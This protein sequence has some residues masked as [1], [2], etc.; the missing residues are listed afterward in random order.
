MLLPAGVAAQEGQIPPMVT[1]RPAPELSGMDAVERLIGN[2]LVVTMTFE[3]DKP[4]Y[5]VFMHLKEDRSA[6][7]TTDLN[8]KAQRRVWFIDDRGELCFAEDVARLVSNDCIR[9]EITG[10]TVVLLDDDKRSDEEPW[11]QV[12]LLPGNPYGL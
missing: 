8:A 12:E 5:K 10:D 6:L 9:L 1:P 3:A 4:P 7:A 2:T 11:I